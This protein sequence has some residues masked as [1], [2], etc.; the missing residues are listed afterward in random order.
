MRGPDS[1]GEQP[2][3]QVSLRNRH[4]GTERPTLAAMTGGEEQS[5]RVMRVRLFSVD[6]PQHCARLVEHTTTNPHSEALAET[7]FE[8]LVAGEALR[9]S[10][11]SS[12]I[13]C[14]RNVSATSV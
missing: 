9:T 13:R 8:S 2:Q 12:A 5:C 6:S 7:C 11:T 14:V 3:A 1:V 10:R 4:A